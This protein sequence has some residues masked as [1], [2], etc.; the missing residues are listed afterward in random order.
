MYVR[1]NHLSATVELEGAYRERQGGGQAVSWAARWQVTPSWRLELE[2]QYD[3]QQDEFLYYRGRVV[4]SFHRF[5]LEFTISH[6]PQQDDTSASVS[7]S[8]TPLSTR[9]ADA[10]ERDRYRDLY[11]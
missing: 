5:A 7:L 3:L 4:R 2:Q 10:F 1:T 8:L 6:D 11:R 9:S